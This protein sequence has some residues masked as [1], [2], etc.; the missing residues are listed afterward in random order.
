[1]VLN[2]DSMADHDITK[3]CNSK[4]HQ[5]VPDS[6]QH[7][8][9]GVEPTEDGGVQDAPGRLVEGGVDAEGHVGGA[10]ADDQEVESCPLLSLDAESGPEIDCKGDNCN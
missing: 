4:R 3:S 6:E 9:K 2:S 5:S 10:V 7:R 8:G 1:M